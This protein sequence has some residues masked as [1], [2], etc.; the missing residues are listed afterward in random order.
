MKLELYQTYSIGK[1][2]YLYLG[3]NKKLL[4]PSEI[5]DKEVYLYFC[6][7]MGNDPNLYSYGMKLY[8]SK[9]YLE[10]LVLCCLDRTFFYHITEDDF[11]TKPADLKNLEMQHF[12]YRLRK[13][14]IGIKKEEIKLWCAK[15]QIAGQLQSYV[16]IKEWVKTDENIALSKETYALFQ[17]AKEHYA[18][19]FF[20][21]LYYAKKDT[22]Y[23][24]RQNGFVYICMLDCSIIYKMKDSLS[25]MDKLKKFSQALYKLPYREIGILP[26]DK[27]SQ[28]ITS[29]EE[30]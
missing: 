2:R 10:Y 27:T 18:K 21:Y 3:I 28:K 25:K 23:L 4:E 16:D 1:E 12:Y 8:T 20:E 5:T 29:Y 24:A 22:F 7:K 11:L 14:N 15:N 9:N 6:Y 17:K 13:K 19:D 30:L 26:L